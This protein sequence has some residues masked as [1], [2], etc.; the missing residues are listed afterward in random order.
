MTRR[1]GIAILLGTAA[2]A[3]APGYA[4]TMHEDASDVIVVTG[5]HPRD[6]ASSGTKTDTPLAETPQSITVITA[7]DIGGRDPGNAR[8]ERRGL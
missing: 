7:D 1:L 5:Q 8:V 6:Q 3:A 4:Q 2:F